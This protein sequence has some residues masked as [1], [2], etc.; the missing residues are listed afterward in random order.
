LV[1]SGEAER[2]GIICKCTGVDVE[3]V[4]VTLEVG[5]LATPHEVACHAHP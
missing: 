5:G 2:L 1:A 3:L 4:E